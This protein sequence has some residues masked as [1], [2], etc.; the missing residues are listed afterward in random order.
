MRQ[1]YRRMKFK[2]LL[3]LSSS[4]CKAKS[5]LVPDIT[6]YDCFCIKDKAMEVCNN[7]CVEQNCQSVASLLCDGCVVMLVNCSLS[8]LNL[9]VYWKQN[10]YGGYVLHSAPCLRVSSPSSKITHFR[11]VSGFFLYT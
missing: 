1:L 8:L 2:E 7:C 4:E 6:R 9:L 11:D 3:V 5:Q 10:N